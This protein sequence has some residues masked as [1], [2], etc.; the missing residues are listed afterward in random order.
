M[1]RDNKM[2]EVEQIVFR[3]FDGEIGNNIISVVE[4]SYFIKSNEIISSICVLDIRKPQVTSY[5]F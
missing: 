2:D 5:S 4:V 3:I 1:V